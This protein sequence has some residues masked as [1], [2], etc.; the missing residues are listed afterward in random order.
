V[1]L[2][3]VHA[4]GRVE[5]VFQGPGAD[6]LLGGAEPDPEMVNWDA[7]IHPDDRAAYDAFNR[8]LGAG[9]ESDVEYRGPHREALVGGPLP[10]GADDDRLWASL[11]HPDDRARWE[12][13]LRRLPGSGPSSN[14]RPTAGG[15]STP[16]TASTPAPTSTS[17]APTAPATNRSHVPSCGTA[18]RTGARDDPL[19]RPA[20]HARGGWMACAAIT[21]RLGCKH[22]AA[23]MPST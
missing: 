13:A 11:L 7:A 15:S 1:Y 2:A 8:E 12:T 17:C 21:G 9:R 19:T 22:V 16:P 10:G 18:P 6:R 20:Q 14:T 3:V 4:D 23:T 5:E